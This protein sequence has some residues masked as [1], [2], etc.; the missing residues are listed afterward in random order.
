MKIKFG[1]YFLFVL[2]LVLESCSSS[3]RYTYFQAESVRKGEVI[4]IPSLREKSSVRFKPDDVLGI[5]VN[6]PAE[7]SLA[8]EYNLPM[9]PSATTENSSESS[10]SQGTGRQGFMIKK[11]GTID[12]PGLGNIKV[13]G[14]TREELEKHLKGLLMMSNLWEE[15]IITVRLLNFNIF[16]I[17]EVGQQGRISVDKD[18][19]NIM[20]ALSLAGGMNMYGKRDDV[21][22]IR[23]RPDGG[24]D[25]I[26][27]DVSREDIISSP[28]YFL[29]QND[30]I[31]VKPISARTQATETSPRLNFITSIMSFGMITLSIILTLTRI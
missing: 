20:E 11:D 31:H 3:R 26:P 2:L 17:G 22:L 10:V 21:D 5:T 1:I 23:Q 19:I 8:S 14:Y 12:F 30:M 29:Q 18:N 28:Y 15:P 27:L 9:I 16:F 7:P 24:Y 4:D 13:A 25:R 6:V